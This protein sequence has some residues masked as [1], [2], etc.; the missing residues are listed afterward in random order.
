MLLFAEIYRY[1]D[2]V[3]K[4]FPQFNTSDGAQFKITQS[5]H[6]VYSEFAKLSRDFMKKQICFLVESFIRYATNRFYIKSFHNIFFY[7]IAKLINY[8][9]VKE[10]RN[11]VKNYKMERCKTCVCTLTVNSKTAL[12]DR[13]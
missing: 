12:Y 8:E 7:S 5:L 3:S 10:T 1:D 13:F 4:T 9:S 11:K 6:R 2:S